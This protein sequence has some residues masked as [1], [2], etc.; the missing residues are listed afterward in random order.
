MQ[1]R[2]SYELISQLCKKTDPILDVGCG[3]G[4]LLKIM[5]EIGYTDL[6]GI[7]LYLNV[8]NPEKNIRLIR[9]D[10]I[11]MEE[12]KK[13][14]LIMF[15]HSLEHM[16]NQI[17]IFKKIVRLLKDNDSHCMICIPLSDSYA[18][19]TYRENWVQLDAPR[20]FYLHSVKSILLLAQ[21]SGLKISNIVYDSNSFQFFGSNL[22]EKG[23]LG[24]KRRNLKNV[25]MYA[26]ESVLKYSRLSR[27]LNNE[28]CGDQAI[29]ILKKG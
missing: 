19:E 15:H 11:F 22:Y 6:T 25:I 8:S 1:P 26:V 21:Q 24:V 23:E 27:K 2:P 20:H 13:Y 18:F 3:D 7:D 29:F 9:Q 28:H 10:M 14:K 16:D 4:Y 12:T 5:E 17:G